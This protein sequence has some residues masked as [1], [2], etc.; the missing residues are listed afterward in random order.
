MT[1]PLLSV[2]EVA[3]R[4]GCTRQAVHNAIGRGQLT[5]R[6]VGHAFVIADDEALAAYEVPETGGR[7]HQAYREKNAP[8]ADRT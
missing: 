5:A 3:Q 2:T 1:P 6:R 4:K 7:L 8:T